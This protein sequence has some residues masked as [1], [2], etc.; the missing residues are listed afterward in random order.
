MKVG[1]GTRCS[2][3]IHQTCAQELGTIS[4]QER[5]QVALQLLLHARAPQAPTAYEE[6]RVAH[7]PAQHCTPLQSSVLPDQVWHLMQT[8]VS[9]LTC[10]WLTSLLLL[11]LSLVCCSLLL[12]AGC[13]E[14][15]KRH[16]LE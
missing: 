2:Y 16:F 12:I 9:A 14:L 5:H 15:V 10:Q 7:V 8:S 4:A 3:S 11:L 1:V 13:R 6:G